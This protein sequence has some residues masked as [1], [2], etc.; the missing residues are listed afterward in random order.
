V[1]DGGDRIT[2]REDAWDLGLE[3]ESEGRRE[4]NKLAMLLGKKNLRARHCEHKEGVRGGVTFTS[5]REKKK[6]R[7]EKSRH[8][9]VFRESGRRMRASYTSGLDQGNK[10][11]LSSQ[12]SW[13]GKRE[14]KKTCGFRDVVIKSSSFLLRRVKKPSPGGSWGDG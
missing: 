11:C 2:Q 5:Q 10:V 3:Y 6:V 9:K 1:V 8:T 13:L 4:E 7:G 14:P 12:K